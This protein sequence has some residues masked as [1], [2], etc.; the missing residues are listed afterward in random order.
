MTNKYIAVAIR[1]KK[2]CEY[3]YNLLEIDEICISPN[4]WYK[5]E[6]LHDYLIKNPGSIVVGNLFGPNLLPA[7]SKNGEKYVKSM[8][9]DSV[10]DN[11]LKLPRR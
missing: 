1:M 10:E 5:K 2:H 9:N 8:P 7:R 6:L 3:S 11:L 4:S